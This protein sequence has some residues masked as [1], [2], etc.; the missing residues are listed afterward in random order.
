MAKSRLGLRARASSPPR[1][2]RKKPTNMIE[3]AFDDVRQLVSDTGDRLL[4][5]P[6]KRKASMKNV[7]ARKAGTARIRSGQERQS[8]AKKVTAARV[9]SGRQRQAAAKKAVRDRRAKTP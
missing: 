1:R 9:R 4:G 7:S 6:G 8:A 5:R 3:R 2:R